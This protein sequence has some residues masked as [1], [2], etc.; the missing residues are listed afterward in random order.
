MERYYYARDKRITVEEIPDVVAVNL[1][2]DER[3]KPK[4]QL[5]TFGTSAVESVRAVE[6]IDLP[7]DVLEAF[8]K[9]NWKFLKPSHQLS[10]AMDAGESI[11][12]AEDTG[13]VLRR[14]D[15]SVAIATNRLN[16]QLREDLSQEECE[17]ALD[18]RGLRVLTILRFAPNLYEVYADGRSDA[19]DTSVELHDD[20]RFTLA[21]PELVEHIPQRF[22][23]T[24]PDYGDQW[25]W[26]N[27][28]QSGGTA[29]ADVSSEEAW[30]LTRGADMRTAVIDNGFDATHEDLTA[31]ITPL[32]GFFSSAGGGGAAMFTQG[33]A[34]IPSGN[35]GTFCAGMVGA[36]HNNSNGGCGGAP[37]CELML[38]AA[39]GDQVGTQTT[40]ARA[41]SYVADPSTEVA[42]LTAADG[43]DILVCS[44]GPNGAV[45]N[46]TVT[47]QL[48]LQFAGTN[49]RSGRGLTIF[50]AASNGNNVDIT[51]DQVVSQADVIAVVRS[52]HNDQEDNAAQGTTA[53]LIAPG[54]NVYSTN[55]GNGYGTSTGTSYAAPCAA[56]C[57]TLALS[58]NPDLTRNELRQIMRDTADQIGGVVY[59]A[60]GHNDD[61]GF[62]R[63]N[64]HQ[65]VLSAARRVE[66]LTPS[67]VFNDVPE[68]ETTARAIV[69]QCFSFESLTFQI[70]S[71]PTTTSGLADSFT[72]LTV[73]SVTI[74]A[75]G[76]TTG[77]ETRIWL[78]HTGTTDGDS[79]TGTVRVRCVETGE[80]WDINLSS[81]TI[82]RQTVAVSL[83][84]DQ[85]GSM[86]WD[87]GDGRKRVEVL[88][89]AAH[90]FVD[91][92]QPDN[93]IGIVRFDHD[94]YPGMAITQAGPE[95][96]GVGRATATAA[97]AS[98]IPN[99]AGA[100]S[101][102]DGIELAGAQLNAVEA[103]YDNTAMIVLTDGQENASKFIADV[104][105]SIDDT[106]FAIGLGEP[107]VINPS[108]LEA[109]TNS[110]GGYVVMTGNLSQDERFILAKYYLQILAGIT[111]EQIV[112][113]PQGNIRPGG[114]K[115]TISFMLN[116]ADAGADVI[117]LT[118][119][120]DAIRFSLETPNGDII[121]P[122]ALPAGVK[123]VTGQTTAYYRFNLPVVTG[124]GKGAATGRWIVHLQ[125]DRAAFKGYLKSLHN[126]P[127]A[128]EYAKAH[129]LRYAVE[130]HA[131]SSI[132]LSA[133]LTQK[134]IVPGSTMRITARLSE[135]GIPVSKRAKVVVRIK[136]AR[137]GTEKTIKLKQIDDGL[138]QADFKGH[139]Y[140]LY[141]ARVM[142]KGRTLRGTPY[143]RECLVSG[144]IY[145]ARP[146][147]DP[148]APDDD[149][150]VGPDCKKQ[151][152]LLIKVLLK[153]RKLA[154]LLRKAIKKHGGD[155][156]KIYACLYKAA[157]LRPPIITPVSIDS[158]IIVPT[159]RPRPLQPV[160]P[161]RPVAF[162]PGR[163][164]VD[165]IASTLRDI[166][167]QIDPKTDLWDE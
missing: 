93:G 89:E 158:D 66:L 23:P 28:G 133:Q 166:A 52:D 26:N 61:Y 105:G 50:W 11:R 41:V 129:G 18:E 122:G 1:S 48:A 42:G 131:R 25:Q 83:V 142:V 106:V 150:P 135:Y 9:A 53:E 87:A 27:T 102:G 10:R 162:D 109:V 94:A 113:D 118:P 29:G 67:V 30:D 57:A 84:L 20:D 157:G 156:T 148:Q 75:P 147:E 116:E 90:T 31:A 76:V 95:V 120:P 80:E 69:W 136:T 17:S 134:N 65:A 110:S 114:D 98:H 32:S 161:F 107:E 149:V 151:F 115:Q 38:V 49:G 81:N 96:F 82:A 36:R 165:E 126:D 101:I 154:R 91:V 63:V 117:L 85:S 35:H 44:L 88:R 97:I 143:T 153:N 145:Q 73:D 77:E 55:S 103:S 104:A 54:V 72:T 6:H 137:L 59:D 70:I 60:A 119:S 68:S 140:G 123:Y 155:Q 13:K 78:S 132:K 86:D 144:A 5:R 139:E 46:L 8:E 2:V 146:P 159:P 21:E 108:A 15:G 14:E 74:P 167:E 4:A 58:V 56:S 124:A 39:L 121:T 3:G 7:N 24:D 45:W 40:L 128:Y 125:C 92:I 163:V 64:A 33:T 100:T 112:L 141:N 138:F 79:A 34:G 22:T 127:K 12:D 47:L 160:Q 62:G 37:E 16:V 111:N 152:R 51:L 164:S 43:A 19:I 99:P 130:V 71:G